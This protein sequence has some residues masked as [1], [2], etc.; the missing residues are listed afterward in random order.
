MSNRRNEDDG[1]RR[2]ILGPTLATT[3]LT[4]LTP[5][6]PF[7]VGRA[8]APTPLTWEA[9]VAEYRLHPSDF[10]LDAMQRTHPRG[11][12]PA[13]TEVVTPIASGKNTG[14]F[15]KHMAVAHF[16]D[17]RL[18]EADYFAGRWLQLEPASF[19]AHNLKAI[20]CIERGELRRA[21][22]HYN[23]MGP[24]RPASIEVIRLRLML[25][26]RM[27]QLANA[28]D[29][30]PALLGFPKLSPQDVILLAE[31]GVRA[32][33]PDLVRAA[34]MRRDQ[35]FHQRGEHMLRE[36]ARIGL[37]RTFA[38]KLGSGGTV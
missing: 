20:I 29:H 4:T 7:P 30:A 2:S 22:E 12:T 18:L 14:M 16:V 28:R 5:P 6:K 33:D 24:M 23:Q 15:M 10:A 37:V 19:D 36:V 1:A 9:A 3:A 11:K 27:N 32:V 34:V 26:L 31:I 21:A 8:L 25:Y 17:G 35:P 13:I 38:A